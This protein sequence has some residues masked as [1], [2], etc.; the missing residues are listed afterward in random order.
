MKYSTLEAIS[1]VY[2]SNII[3]PYASDNTKIQKT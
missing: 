1:N 2:M 3:L